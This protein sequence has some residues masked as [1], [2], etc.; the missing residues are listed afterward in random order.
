MFWHLEIKPRFDIKALKNITALNLTMPSLLCATSSSN[1]FCT[2]H[3]RSRIHEDVDVLASIIFGLMALSN[4]HVSIHDT[5][6]FFNVCPLSFLHYLTKITSSYHHLHPIS[7]YWYVDCTLLWYVVL[8][9]Y[10]VYMYVRYSQSRILHFCST[11]IYISCT[12]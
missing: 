2:G 5:W 6:L 11:V 9:P 7:S 1:H 3:T 8:I 4:L 12:Q 10:A